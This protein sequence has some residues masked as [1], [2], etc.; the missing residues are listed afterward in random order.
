M[1]FELTPE[2]AGISLVVTLSTYFIAFALQVYML[3]LN[4]KQSKVK[5]I[6]TELVNEVKAIRQLLEEKKLRK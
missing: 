6:T 5:E 1:A 3:Y 2:L 4:W